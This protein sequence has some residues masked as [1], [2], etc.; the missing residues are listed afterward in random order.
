MYLLLLAIG[1]FAAA[2]GGV[3]IAFGIPIH[4][5]S[6]G[7]T[8]II[9]GT[10]VMTGGLLMIGVAAA[11]R[12]LQRIAE[13]LAGRPAAARPPRPVPPENM[14]RGAEAGEPLTPAAAPRGGGRIP[15]PSKPPAPELPREPRPAEPR[16][17]SPLDMPVPEE[18]FPERPPPNIVAM[19]RLANEPPAS[20]EPDGMPPLPQ[21]GGRAAAARNGSA[22]MRAEPK[23]EQA[24]RPNAGAGGRGDKAPRLGP[25]GE[26]AERG[27]RGG[28]FDS[29]WPAEQK[30][31]P[32]AAEPPARS[33]RL[34]PVPSEG[35][36]TPA[37]DEEPMPSIVRAPAPGPRSA[38]EERSAAAI[39]KSGVIDGMAYT[40]YTDGS[41]EAQLPQGLM[42]FNSIQELR[43]HLEKSA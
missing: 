38:P 20:V 43:I 29:V 42:R 18:I 25:A 31:R 6:F 32:H 36:A 7:N 15:F 35:R 33:S 30:A 14:L 11:V 19:P 12:Q 41:I 27:G 2:A 3:L 39:L 13:A 26:R 40:L 8:L 34:E 9:A 21:I 22:E 4:E 24:R 28:F 10:T 17:T 5:F 37:T 1:A 23:L 16:M